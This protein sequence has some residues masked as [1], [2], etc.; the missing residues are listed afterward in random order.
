MT[1]LGSC[2]VVIP[3]AS[4]NSVMESRNGRKSLM[5]IGFNNRFLGPVFL[6]LL[7]GFLLSIYVVFYRETFGLV[8]MLAVTAILS[9]PAMLVSIFTRL[10]IM[11]KS[12]EVVGSNLVFVT[13]WRKHRIPLKN[14][15]NYQF[16]GHDKRSQKLVLV[17]GGEQYSIYIGWLEGGQSACRAF[18]DELDLKETPWGIRKVSGDSV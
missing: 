2:G 4:A 6:L 10:F 16:Q 11:K 15:L 3:N 7:A 13:E 9:L 12:L 8:L 1:S 18:F 5:V 14:L 17:A